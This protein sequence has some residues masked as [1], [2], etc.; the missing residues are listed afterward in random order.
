MIA[1]GDGLEVV[2][3]A[4]LTPDVVVLDSR[5]E[6]LPAARGLRSARDVVVTE[7]PGSGKGGTS[8][9]RFERVGV[10]T[11]VMQTSARRR[12]T[13]ALLL[14]DGAGAR[15]I[16]ASGCA[17]RSRSSSTAAATASAAATSPG[18]RSDRGS[19]TPRPCRRSLG[20]AARPP[21]LP[22]APDRPHRGGG[23][24]RDY[25]GGPPVGASTC[26]TRS[27]SLSPSSAGGSRDPLAD[28]RRSAGRRPPG[29][30]HGH[31]LRRRTAEHDRLQ[32]RA[33]A[34]TSTPR[35]TRVPRRFAAS[36]AARLY[37]NGLSRRPVALVM[38]PGADPATVSALTSQ[39]K[40]A[41]GTVSRRLP[42][43]LPAGR[44]ASRR[45]SSTP[46]A[47]S[48]ASSS[49]V[50][51]PHT[52]TYPRIGQLARHRHRHPRHDPRGQQDDDVA[53]VRQSLVA[54]R[55]SPAPAGNPPTAPLVLVVTGTEVDQAI[56][57]GLDVRAGQHGAR[58]RRVGPTGAP[59]WSGSP[60]T[61]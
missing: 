30:G 57:D 28:V 60:P 4:G 21:R 49:T 5:T 8:T 2:R 32:R 43:R 55:C 33:G 9:E 22:R 27:T 25:P 50:R 52:T 54:R 36:V 11:V 46:S 48:S 19:S 12:P 45:A 20:S 58:G 41:G 40:L 56:A 14:A 31:R 3:A 42:G 6:E 1:T 37:G 44:R 61:A 24:H 29:S 35:P 16:V 17:A 51:R 15:P 47:C 7:P 23:G 18:S 34:A 38:L 59:T 13:P 53:A 26:A 10:R 39:I